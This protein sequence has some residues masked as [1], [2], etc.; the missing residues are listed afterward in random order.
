MFLIKKPI[1]IAT[2]AALMLA[3]CGEEQS[4]S[5]TK[6]AT[7]QDT[8]AV[9][10]GEKITRQD[11]ESVK[12]Q[13]PGHDNDEQIVEQLIELKL[14]AQKARKEGLDKEAAIKAELERARESILA[15]HLVR[16]ML[17]TKTFTDA[18][19]KAEYDEVVAKMP[20]R[21]EYKAAHILVEDEAKAKEL[22]AKLT[23]GAD[24]TQLAK[25]HSTD[26]GSKDQGGDLGWFEASMM[27]PEFALAVTELEPGK[28]SSAPVKTQFGWHII[29]LEDKRQVPPPPFEAVKPQLTNMLRQ[30]AVE[31]FVKDA[32]AQAKVEIKLASA[33]KSEDESKDKSE[34]KP[35][36]TSAKSGS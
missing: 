29:K 35:A 4:A 15:N 14:L 16:K 8:V 11:L 24:F 13:M 7:S 20:K 28:M 32:R 17:E 6:A 12:A 9:V 1:L 26:P 19:L 18:E 23:N 3:G 30:K 27:V 21:E 10:N 2:A 5:A 33:D 25:E 22:L 34:G 31:Q 36:E